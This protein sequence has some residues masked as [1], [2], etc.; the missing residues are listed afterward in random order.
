MSTSLEASFEDSS[1]QR[2]DSEPIDL[3]CVSLS[4][5]QVEFLKSNY[6]RKIADFK[7]SQHRRTRSQIMKLDEIIARAGD[8]NAALEKPNKASKMLSFWF[9]IFFFVL[10]KNF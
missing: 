1:A 4:E 7:E 8:L 3:S 9:L 2:F 6:R 10:S 5:I